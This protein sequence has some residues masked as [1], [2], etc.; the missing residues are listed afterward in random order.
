MSSIIDLAF[1]SDG[2]VSRTKWKLTE[3]C[4][5]SDHQAI[6]MTVTGRNTRDGLPKF[7]GPKWKD[8]RFEGETYTLMLLSCY[9]TGST[10]EELVS[11]VYEMLNT[12]CDAAMPRRQYVPYI[13]PPATGRM[14]RLEI[15]GR[16]ALG[17]EGPSARK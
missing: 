15:Y 4:T 10:V 16:H 17:R 2:L 8:S 9:T 1:F 7:T 13:L 11:G 14:T 6:V 3:D 5:N 12:A